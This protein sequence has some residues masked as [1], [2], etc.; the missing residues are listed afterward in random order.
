MPDPSAVP[1][2][3]FHWMDL[4]GW[5]GVFGLTIVLAPEM[6]MP[7]LGYAAFKGEIHPVAALIAGT[8]GGTSGST[9][10]Y[11]A[12]RLPN[13]ERLRGWITRAEQW[14]LFQQ[15]DVDAVAGFYR[16]YGLAAVLF[17]RLIPTVR[18]VVSV[19]AGLL[20]MPI[21]SFLSFTLLGTAISNALLITAGYAAGTNWEHLV[22]RLGVFGA[23]A[24]TLLLALLVIFVLLRLRDVLLRGE[25]HQRPRPAPEGCSRASDRKGRD[26]PRSSRSR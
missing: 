15:R 18:S 12:A 14:R 9:M 3:I 23:A 13:G 4:L 7:F 6:V 26:A 19:P 11:L 8:L 17:G 2:L 22:E 5:V 24:T 21:G 10:I 1:E 20:S 16:R 25:A